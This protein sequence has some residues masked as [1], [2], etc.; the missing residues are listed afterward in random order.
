MSVIIKTPL[1]AISFSALLATLSACDAPAAIEKVQPQAFAMHKQAEF[2]KSTKSQ[3]GSPLRIEFEAWTRAS[4]APP[5]ELHFDPLDNSKAST[6]SAN[7]V[8]NK[9]D[10]ELSLPAG[11][12]RIRAKASGY[13]VELP[14]E[15]AVLGHQEPTVIHGAIRD[16][17]TLALRL[18]DRVR[19][20][21]LNNARVSLTPVTVGQ[22][23]PKIAMLQ[24]DGSYWAEELPPGRYRI[25]VEAQGQCQATTH[26]IDVTRSESTVD[27]AVQPGASLTG[28]VV[29][30]GSGVQGARVEFSGPD[31]AGLVTTHSGPDGHF[32]L[33][34]LC[35]ERGILRAE[36]SDFASYWASDVRVDGSWRENN[37]IQLSVGSVFHAKFVDKSGQPLAH[38]EVWLHASGSVFDARRSQHAKSDEHGDI[39]APHLASIPEAIT[40]ASKQTLPWTKTLDG[41]E[42]STFDLGTIAVP[43]A[44]EQ[45]F[46]IVDEQGRSIA[47]AQLSIQ[48]SVFDRGDWTANEQGRATLAFHGD[49][50]FEV[51]ARAPG[52]ASITSIIAGP[53]RGV[54]RLELK[55]HARAQICAGFNDGLPS[56]LILRRGRET[57]MHRFTGRCAQLD[58]IVPDAYTWVIERSGRKVGSWHELRLSAGEE[59]H[60][61]ATP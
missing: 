31:G 60:V 57:V 19:G 10:R 15:I 36:H 11:R 17:A 9:L 20:L 48:R 61:D 22:A 23:T 5:V 16:R 7:F 26:E 53:T 1:S 58:S 28:R 56:T 45:S 39:V 55:A 30:E 32:R 54:V 43:P 8:N 49:E 37:D 40:I 34:N 14:H 2:P 25:E 29:H 46:A 59:A 44:H 47:N 41:D 38:T 21:P 6:A 50:P 3:P 13:A 42:R 27:L 18:H 35:P 12:Y 33:M 24:R 4:A 52:Y 51:Q